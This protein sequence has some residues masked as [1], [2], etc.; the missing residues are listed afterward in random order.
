MGR[1]CLPSFLLIGTLLL[2]VPDREAL[3]TT[4]FQVTSTSLNISIPENCA[5][6][7]IGTC[8]SHSYGVEW[9]LIERIYTRVDVY[10]CADAIPRLCAYVVCTSANVV[11]N[12][13][14]MR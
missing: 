11:E 9:P 6:N 14:W 8:W 5:T 1:S 3:I 4:Q 13:T 7:R 10:V 12:G 2:K